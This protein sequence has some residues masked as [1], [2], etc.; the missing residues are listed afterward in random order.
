MD[1][2]SSLTLLNLTKLKAILFKS[3]DL[4][5]ADDK[6]YFPMRHEAFWKHRV[7]IISAC[8]ELII[9]G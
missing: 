3:A 5:L 4:L 8:K 6:V 2:L 7:L 1:E 9:I